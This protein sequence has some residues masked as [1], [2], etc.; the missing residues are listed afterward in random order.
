MGAAQTEIKEEEENLDISR[1]QNDAV[2]GPIN[3]LQTQEN[4]YIFVPLEMLS[5][6]LITSVQARY[7]QKWKVERNSTSDELRN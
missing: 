7:P 6:G 5:S 1:W 2:F 4:I 3:F